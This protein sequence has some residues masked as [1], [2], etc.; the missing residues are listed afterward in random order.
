MFHGS[1]HVRG[2]PAATSGCTDEELHQGQQRR[3]AILL[4]AVNPIVN[5]NL[6]IKNNDNNKHLNQIKISLTNFEQA[7]EGLFDNG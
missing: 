2:D 4:V 5:N 1:L 7:F 3:L 6:I